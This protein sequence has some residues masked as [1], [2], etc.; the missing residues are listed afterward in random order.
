MPPRSQAT[1]SAPLPIAA[2]VLNHA[3]LPVTVYL[4]TIVAMPAGTEES[5][6]QPAITVAPFGAAATAT[7]LA[8]LVLLPIRFAKISCPGT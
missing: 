4:A 3:R 2:Y 8:G 1:A 6:R 5:S 7:E